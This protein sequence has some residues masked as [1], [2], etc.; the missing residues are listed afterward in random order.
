MR[1]RFEAAGLVEGED[2]ISDPIL[3]AKMTAQGRAK[4]D[5]IQPAAPLDMEALK[6][7]MVATWGEA[8]WNAHCPPPPHYS[9]RKRTPRKKPSPE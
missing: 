7:R 1:E 4:S 6:A 5:A 9:E 2:F 8:Y 3:G